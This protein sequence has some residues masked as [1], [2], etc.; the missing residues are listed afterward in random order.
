[1]RQKRISFGSPLVVMLVML[2]LPVQ[3]F[4]AVCFKASFGTSEA[5]IKLTVAGV[6]EEF[7][8]LVGEGIKTSC[9]SSALESAPLTGA[10]HLRPDGK[11]H[12]TLSI[13]GTT[14]CDP[15]MFQGLLD[16]P[17]FNTG[18]GTYDEINGGFGDATFSAAA[19]LPLPQ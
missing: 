7:F 2:L 8:S 13:G 18:N 4:A 17:S 1:M 3:T 5:T 15:I 12:F 9:A 19:C 11:V 16:P 14:T 6:A 10:A